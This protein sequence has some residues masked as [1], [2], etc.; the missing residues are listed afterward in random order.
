MYSSTYNEV[1]NFLNEKKFK[2]A[3]DLLKTIKDK[4]AKWY[5]LAGV[6]A[7]NIG[8][9]EEGEKYINEA[10]NMEPENEIYSQSLIKY[11]RYRDDYHDRA[12][13]YNHRRR[14]DLDG[15]C[16][17]CPGSCCD[18]CLTLWCL[19]SC[20]ECMGGDFIACC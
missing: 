5:Y 1:D 20:C 4:S 16:C 10:K 2:D 11:N 14:N 17:C 3:Y 15:C 18:D 8:L 6:C 13:R 9:Y 12:Y 7:M 19:D